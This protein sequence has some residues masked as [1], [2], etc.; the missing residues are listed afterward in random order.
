MSRKDKEFEQFLREA[1]GVPRNVTQQ[2]ADNRYG[3]QTQTFRAEK[4]P[5]EE[6]AYQKARQAFELQLARQEATTD[7]VDLKD[8]DGNILKDSRNRNRKTRV[9]AET[10]GLTPEEEERF[11]VVGFVPSAGQVEQAFERSR[12]AS[13]KIDET[14]RQNKRI[15]PAYWVTQADFNQAFGRNY[16][17]MSKEDQ[18]DFFQL[19]QNAPG[20]TRRTDVAGADV[21]AVV[22]SRQ[23]PSSLPTFQDVDGIKVPETALGYTQREQ[24]AARLSGFKTAEEAKKMVGSYSEKPDYVVKRE[25]E[26]VVNL[27]KQME[28]LGI[29]KKPSKPES[30]TLPYSDRQR[31]PLEDPR[32]ALKF[33]QQY[34]PETLTPEQK[35]A[36][37]V[38]DP[39]LPYSRRG[40]GANYLPRDTSA[41]PAP[42]PPPA[43]DP[44]PL[45]GIEGPGYDRNKPLETS[46]NFPERAPEGWEK[47]SVT[48][49]PSEPTPR[50]IPSPS[51]LLGLG[52][53]KQPKPEISA[54]QDA[55]RRTLGLAPQQA[56]KTPPAPDLS[57][58]GLYGGVLGQMRFARG[59]RPSQQE[60]GV[61]G[62]S[63][64]E[65]E[66][67]RMM[68]DARESEP[69]PAPELPPPPAPD[70]ESLSDLELARM[71]RDAKES[72][73]SGLSQAMRLAQGAGEFGRNLDQA[74]GRKV[75]EAGQK[76]S[77][78]AKRFRTQRDENARKNI[79]R[80]EAQ[81]IRVPGFDVAEKGFGQ[82]GDFPAQGSEDF[83]GQLLSKSLVNLPLGPDETIE[84]RRKEIV[85][86]YKEKMLPSEYAKTWGFASDEPSPELPGRFDMD[87]IRS[88]T[89]VT[90]QS[91]NAPQKRSSTTAPQQVASAISANQ[92]K[93]FAQSSPISQE[94]ASRLLAA[95]TPGQV[96]TPLTGRPLTTQERDRFKFDSDVPASVAASMNR[97]SPVRT[98]LGQEPLT[99]TEKSIAG[100]KKGERE[101]ASF[102]KDMSDAE[103]NVEFEKIFGKEQRNLST[104]MKKDMIERF[105]LGELMQQG[106]GIMGMN[107]MYE[108][109][110]DPDTGELKLNP[111][112]RD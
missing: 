69:A 67:S 46:A 11:G 101:M 87:P 72:E 37:G 50:Q 1:R 3:G 81:G 78:I 19:V 9:A 18:R 77:D 98:S 26:D 63:R 105:R 57:G 111:K 103:V 12:E 7:V 25:A 24:E 51:E 94:M 60:V 96:S 40:A 20:A 2:I 95:Q 64:S 92:K 27:P 38:Y 52:A 79:E 43:P 82:H 86:Y 59:Q 102:T 10:E 84:D 6:D 16:N 35:R 8:K 109:E 48:G 112:K 85:Q 39:N 107:P 22:P 41:A 23:R 110:I 58:V 45:Y 42:E 66:L 97:V 65:A 90:T 108:M 33:V 80:L 14:E 31:N 49:R 4:S 70:P 62:P 32:K 89:P 61:M 93:Q 53:P 30:K 29:S 28:F 54:A 47:Q 68:R 5:E 73:P 34:A 44:E 21:G 56:A 36:L 88:K 104:E 74:A 91:F 13:A 83:Q 99:Q 76:I 100:G 55:A 17:P 75:R 15:S 106:G 71:K